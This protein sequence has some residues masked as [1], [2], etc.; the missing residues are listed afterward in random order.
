M[1]LK[2][3]VSIHPMLMFIYTLAAVLPPFLFVSIHP[4]L[5]FIGGIY[6]RIKFKRDVSIHPM[7]IFIIDPCEMGQVT[8][9]FNTSHVNVYPTYFRHF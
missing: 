4:M 9:S 2:D 6:K 5:M 8:D 7:L 3:V 1:I